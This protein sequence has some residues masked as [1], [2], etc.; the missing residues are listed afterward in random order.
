MLKSFVN[1]KA[2]VALVGVLAT[3][4][5]VQFAPDSTVFHVLTVVA[6]LATAFGVWASGPDVQQPS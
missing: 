3:A 5:L 6:A 4:A 2:Y 1:A